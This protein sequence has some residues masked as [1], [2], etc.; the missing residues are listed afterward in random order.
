MENR[1][2]GILSDEKQSELPDLE[3]KNLSWPTLDKI[4]VAPGVLDGVIGSEAE[5]HRIAFN[6]G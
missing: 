2:N 5:E 3:S 1:S 6:Q 4:G